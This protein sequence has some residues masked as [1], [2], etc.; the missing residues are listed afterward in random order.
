M[1]RNHSIVYSLASWVALPFYSF[2][3][4]TVIEG[5]HFIPK[6]GPVVIA[7]NH[8]SFLD[9]L[10]LGYL[11]RRRKRQIHFLA[12]EDLF[13]NPLLAKFFLACGQI[14]VARG[15][16]NASEALVHAHRS[17]EKGHCVAIYP[18]GT[19]PNDLVQLPIKSGAIRLAQESGAPLVVV[20]SWGAH[21]IWRKGMRPR[22]RFRHKHVL[23][24]Q[25]PVQID[26]DEDVESYKETLAEKMRAATTHAQSLYGAS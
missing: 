9:P 14:P 26:S 3:V 7:S 5:E 16:H 19:M 12:K 15:A 2:F 20:G 11:L 1:S 21:E 18:E 23:V 10:A 13:K 4:K 24:V 17:L 8:I 25:P 6:D 22:L